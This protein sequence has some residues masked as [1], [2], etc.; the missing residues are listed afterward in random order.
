M[1]VAS[2]GARVGQAWENVRVMNGTPPYIAA[3]SSELGSTLERRSGGSDT[4]GDGGLGFFV[5]EVG[6]GGSE[7][8]VEVKPGTRRTT[9]FCMLC[10]F[11]GPMSIILGSR[12]KDTHLHSNPARWRRLGY[13]VEDKV[14]D[15]LIV[16]LSRIHEKR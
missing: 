16:V 11:C 4:A 9:S 2:P 8:T 7:R 13:Y 15:I 5:A 3:A 14:T 10:V 6:R 12:V 1:R